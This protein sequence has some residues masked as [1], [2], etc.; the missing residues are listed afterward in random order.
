MEHQ[1]VP[2]TT[3][4]EF[5]P[6]NVLPL[7]QEARAAKK[8][9]KALANPQRVIVPGGARVVKFKVSVPIEQYAGLQR[10]EGN[11]DAAKLLAILRMAN[12][13]VDE[14]AKKAYEERVK[15]QET[16][17]AQSHDAP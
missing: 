16:E 1:R 15:A 6:E 8:A 7:Q 13:R 12:R 17:A 9:A 2:T 3:E 4:T 10:F 11:T 5:L 14:V